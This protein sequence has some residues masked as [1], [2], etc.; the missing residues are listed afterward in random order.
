[1]ASPYADLL[2]RQESELQPRTDLLLYLHVQRCA[3]KLV[4]LGLNFSAMDHSTQTCP[5][6]C[7]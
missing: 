4:P 1:V 3:I 5:K 7:S 2:R 6:H